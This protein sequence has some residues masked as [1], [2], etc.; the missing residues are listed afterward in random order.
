MSGTATGGPD[1]CGTGQLGFFSHRDEI[2]PT[3]H[4]GGA[5]IEFTT[6]E[7]ALRNGTYGADDVIPGGVGLSEDEIAVKVSPGTHVLLSGA[8]LT[9]TGVQAN[10]VSWQSVSFEAGLGSSAE[11]AVDLV[12]RLRSDGRISISAPTEPGDYMV[13]LGVGWQ[14]TCTEGGGVA[15]SRIK[16]VAP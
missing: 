2:P 10:V 5:T 8:G 6:V 16:V 4:F 14:S 1:G 7:V 15:Y 12:W 9:L 11:S 3:L 13:Y